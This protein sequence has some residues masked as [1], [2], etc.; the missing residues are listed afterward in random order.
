MGGCPLEGP[1]LRAAAWGLTDGSRLRRRRTP[2]EDATELARDCQLLTLSALP[3]WRVKAGQ[4]V[5]AQLRVREGSHAPGRK[6]AA[7]RKGSHARSRRARGRRLGA[8]A[9]GDA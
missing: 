4:M 5:G 8:C 2:I 9:C 6:P 1:A 3:A 7:A